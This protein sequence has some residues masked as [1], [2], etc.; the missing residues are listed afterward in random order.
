[1]LW[2][3]F[4]HLASCGG[5]EGHLCSMQSACYLQPWS[6]CQVGL[7]SLSSLCFL[8]FCFCLYAEQFTTSFFISVKQRVVAQLIIK[9]QVA[10]MICLAYIF[11]VVGNHAIFFINLNIFDLCSA[12][13]YVCTTCLQYLQRP[14]EVI[15]SRIAVTVVINYQ[16][17]TNLSSSVLHQLI[18]LNDY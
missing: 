2:T 14:E 16:M 15:P 18:Y 9:I 1:M 12:F 17:G 4:F 5:F 6:C 7:S 8:V 3:L 13:L 10:Q 11:T